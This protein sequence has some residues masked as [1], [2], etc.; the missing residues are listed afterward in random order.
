MSSVNIALQIPKRGVTVNSAGASA[1]VQIPVASDG[2]TLPKYLRIAASV[3]AY[4]ALG[5]SGVTAAAGDIMVQPG[6]ALVVTRGG[7]TWVAA[8][9]VAAAGV[10]QISGVENQ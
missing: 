6:D 10:V 2:T 1:N 3:A 8:I 7:A 9:Q 5:P 4:V